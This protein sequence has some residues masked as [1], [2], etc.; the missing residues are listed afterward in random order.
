MT[1]ARGRSSPAG[2]RPWASGSG[3]KRKERLLDVWAAVAG[4]DL[5]PGTV[6]RQRPGAVPGA[7]PR[8]AEVHLPRCRVAM[9]RVF[10]QDGGAK[11]AE[12]AWGRL[13]AS[14]PRA[15]P[16]PY[17]LNRRSAAYLPHLPLLLRETQ[18]NPAERFP[19]SAKSEALERI[20]PLGERHNRAAVQEFV[21]HDHAER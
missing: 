21:D 6:D 14:E 13:P 12:T 2:R 4:V 5:L 3:V 16:T 10:A 9:G 7:A 20:V 15:E 8:R 17:C 18:D 11:E 1:T 19:L